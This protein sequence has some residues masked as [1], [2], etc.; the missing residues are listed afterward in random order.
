MVVYL[1]TQGYTVDRQRVRR[2]MQIMGLETMYP[3]PHLSRAGEPS[4]R[5]PYLLR[6]VVVDRIDQVWS[7]DVRHFGACEIPV[8]NRRG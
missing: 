4:V 8:T 7:C 1:Q 6:G 2:L 5:Y 3:K